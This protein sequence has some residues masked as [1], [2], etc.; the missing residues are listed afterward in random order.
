MLMIRYIR[1][2]YRHQLKSFCITCTCRR[3]SDPT[4]ATCVPT[5]VPG[6]QGAT[7]E[8]ATVRAGGGVV[9]VVVVVV[10]DRLIHFLTDC[11]HT[12]SQKLHWRYSEPLLLNAIG[13]GLSLV[14]Y[15]CSAIC[16]AALLPLIT[17]PQESCLV[18]MQECRVVVTWTRVILMLTRTR[19]R[20]RR[21]RRTAMVM[22]MAK[23]IH[24][25]SPP[26]PTPP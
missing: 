6:V 3:P 24:P 1:L 7:Q 15:F 5:A 10:A 22:A 17:G 16:S 25:P 20:S 18:G 13:Y 21:I 4:I 8:G 26:L 9:V 12:D 23:I 2:C 14:K 11:C 19:K